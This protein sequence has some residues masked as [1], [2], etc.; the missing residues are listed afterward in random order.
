MHFKGKN[1]Y[2]RKEPKKNIM[3]SKLYSVR[4]KMSLLQQYWYKNVIYTFYLKNE[5]EICI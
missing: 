5:V 1:D 3:L 4:R 2:M